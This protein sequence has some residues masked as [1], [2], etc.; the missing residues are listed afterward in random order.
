MKSKLIIA[1]TV[2]VIAYPSTLTRGIA[3]TDPHA[4]GSGNS[5]QVLFSADDLDNLL[6]PIALYP[7]PLLAQLLPAATFVDQ[8]I[9]ASQW[10]RANN[11]PA[12]INNQPW[13]TSVK[14]L[15]GFPD[16][17]LKMSSNLDWT[18][19]LGQAYVSQFN[20]VSASIQR[21]RQEARTS[22][23]LV[24]TPQ[25]IV[26][27]EQGFITILP[28][29][30]SLIF[31]PQY[32]PAYVWGPST[33]TI[34]AS[35]LLSFGAGV[36]LGSW[37]NPGW[38]RGWGWGRGGI[39]NVNRT[40]IN[41]NRNIM[42]R[43]WNAGNLNRFPIRH[44]RPGPGRPG[45]AV[46]LPGRPG[47]PGA[48]RPNIPNRPGTP[49]AN[50]PNIP[51]TPNRPGT[52]GANRPNIPGTPNRPGTPGANR[53]TTPGTNRPGTP[54]ANR[55]TTPSTPN[56]PGT[57]GMGGNRPSTSGG[58]PT[59]RS[60]MSRPSGGGGGGRARS[61]GGHRGGGHRGGGGRRR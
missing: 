11:N 10:L 17:L 34:V 15:A 48:N 39:F 57:P 12:G 27:A 55:P 14:A 19:A 18:T 6:A 3:A 8:I 61:H 52:P 60:S 44:G 51:G 49:G 50:R 24:S 20:D 40:T 35:S 2:L 43:R 26:G 53:P 22:G 46:H 7:D 33:G 23:A 54:S 21:L 31:V 28:A 56:R 47:T 29:Q 36:A 30:P 16:V 41:I 32:N 38:N 5:A 58:R 25:Q 9:Q 13:D 4:V 1:I 59:N 42:N 45:G 37:W